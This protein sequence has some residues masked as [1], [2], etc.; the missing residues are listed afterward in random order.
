M[1]NKLLSFLFIVLTA[2]VFAQPTL[3]FTIFA[4][5]FDSPIA[6]EHCN[7]SRL[8]V[9]EQPGVIKILDSLGNTLPADF[10]DITNKVNNGGNEQGLLGLAFHPD[11][12]NNGYF[13]VN[14]INS[15]QNTVIARYS[16]SGSDPNDADENSEVI[17]LGI[18]QPF[19]NH[20]GGCMHFGDDGYLYIA[21][22]DGGSGGDP[23]GNGQSTS[24]LLGKT[25][26]IDIDGAFPYTIPVDNP[27]YGNPDTLQE[28]WAY[29][30]RNAWRWS[31]DRVNG[32]MWIGDVGQDLWEEVDYEPAN[33][34]G[35]LNYGW[36]CWE[37]DHVYDN[38]GCGPQGNYTFPVLE[39]QHSNSNGCSITGGYRYR[40]ALYGGLYGYY[41]VTDYCSGRFWV[42]YDN[43]GTW[44]N[45]NLGQLL[46]NY[47]ELT[48][49][50]ENQYGELFLAKRNGTIYQIGESTSCEPSADIYTLPSTV[51]N[52][53][54][55]VCVGTTLYTPHNNDFTYQ[56][57]LNGNDIP[58]ANSSSWTTT[59]SGLYSVTVMSAVCSNADT[60]Y[61][62]VHSLPVVSFS[63]ISGNYDLSDTTDYPLT[64]SPPGGTFSGNGLNGNN[65]VNFNPADAGLGTH[66]I[67]YSYTDQWGCSNSTSQEVTI[68][69]FPDGINSAELFQQVKIYPNPSSGNFN[70]TIDSKQNQTVEIE[71]FNQLGSLVWENEKQIQRG[72]QTFAIDLQTLAS[73][74]YMISISSADETINRKICVLR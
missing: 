65:G 37:G 15:A 45:Y 58:G 2:N 50:G 57:Q 63:G 41:V 56:W 46:G 16:V 32:D 8:F 51:V 36:N 26:R 66:T 70:L 4:T 13:Y 21:L 31:F 24:T 60:S 38:S 62:V 64:G 3:T 9:V 10:L 39:Y 5:G 47:P 42:I 54:I 55:H 17:L 48:S 61:L 29:G 18:D 27:F 22:G 59:Q 6:M 43:G 67:M 33:S 40:G 23:Y 35:G 73:G 49:F 53:T 71:I 1:K 68:D 12:Q 25:L 19:S 74:F 34:P 14:Y 44:A 72:S 20:N 52:D 7:D 30:M 69:S 28:I 11:Y